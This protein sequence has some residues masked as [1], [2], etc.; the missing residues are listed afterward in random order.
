M[1]TMNSIAATEH[2][3]DLLRRAQEGQSAP[4]TRVRRW[5]QLK[6][7]YG[8]RQERWGSPARAERRLDADAACATC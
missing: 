1:E 5:V 3:Q 7:M 6:H 8:S 4:R 2:R